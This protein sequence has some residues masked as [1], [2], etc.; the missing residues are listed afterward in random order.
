MAEDLLAVWSSSVLYADQCFVRASTTILTISVS[1]QAE[2]ASL[3]YCFMV[4]L[5]CIEQWVS[6]SSTISNWYLGLSCSLNKVLIRGKNSLCSMTSLH[7]CIIT[8]NAHLPAKQLLLADFDHYTACSVSIYA[9]SL[10]E[11]GCSSKRQSTSEA[12][13]KT[14][15]WQSFI[16]QRQ[17]YVGAKDNS[18]HTLEHEDNNDV[19]KD[20][21]ST[22]DVVC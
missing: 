9:L 2:R 5:G 20:E 10:E 8:A 22:P 11:L 3:K 21:A 1:Y 17:W 19:Q 15:H 12:H 4:Y 18:N 7:R 13:D 16:F 14:R 6:Q